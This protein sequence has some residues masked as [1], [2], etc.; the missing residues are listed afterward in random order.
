[1]SLSC[2]MLSLWKST[3]TLC[4]CLF[5]KDSKA[6]SLLD[7]GVVKAPNEGNSNIQAQVLDI[8]SEHSL[9]DLFPSLTLTGL[10]GE[11]ADACLPIFCFPSG[12]GS[13][14]PDLPPWPGELSSFSVHTDL[15]GNCPPGQREGSCREEAFQSGSVHENGRRGRLLTGHLNATLYASF[16]PIPLHNH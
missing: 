1:M 6:F 12:S 5:A 16:T 4:W 15:Y 10:Q 8:S 2:K 11:N 13:P 14:S 7:T 9:S 3:H